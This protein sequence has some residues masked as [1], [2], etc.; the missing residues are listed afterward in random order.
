MITQAILQLSITYF[1][2]TGQAIAQR[3]ACRGRNE[4]ERRRGK[5][6]YIIMTN[7][8]NMT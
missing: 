5:D 4:G 1:T 8:I 2:T 7:C 3:C 6:I